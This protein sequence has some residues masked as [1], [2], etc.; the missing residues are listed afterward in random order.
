MIQIGKFIKD[1]LTE[2]DGMTYDINRTVL[3]SSFIS[4]VSF[5]AWHIHQGGSFDYTAWGT[6]LAAILGAGGAAIG[7]KLS[8][9]QSSPKKDL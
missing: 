3:L 2:R 9:E 4:Y 8:S 1:I 7:F 6:G 5:T